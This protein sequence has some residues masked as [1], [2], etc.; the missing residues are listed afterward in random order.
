M[1]TNEIVLLRGLHSAM[2]TLSPTFAFMQGGQCAEYVDVL[3]S[4]R[5][6][7]G[8]YRMYSFFTR[9]ESCILTDDT[10]P[11]IICPLIG[12]LP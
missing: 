12:R 5:S 1:V 8:T 4:Y 2:R 10:T 11:T 3:F 6:Y 9:M 7:F